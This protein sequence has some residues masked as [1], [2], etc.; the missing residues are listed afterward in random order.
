MYQSISHM[1]AAI[2]EKSF[3]AKVTDVT[4]ELGV[5]SIQGP[6]SREILSKVTDFNLSNQFIAPNSSAIIKIKGTEN[7]QFNV[8]MLRVSFVGELG[9]ELHIPKA[10]CAPV[11][12]ALMSAGSSYGLRNGGYR[13]LYALSSEKG[14]HLWGFDLRTDDTP[15]EANLGFTCRKNGEYKGKNAIEKQKKNGVHKRLVFLTL[16]DQNPLWG[17]EAVY[18]NG[19]LVGHLRR[20]DYGYSLNKSIGQFYIKRSDNKPVDDEYIKSGNYQIEIMGHK[21][22]A[23]CF[24]RSPFD[25]NGKRILGNYN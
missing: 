17:L 23:K 1:R 11:Y 21:Y 14:Y 19:D 16:N 13:S 5:L 18:R 12:N 6:K 24:I 9:F 25:S 15:L 3:R 10:A 8:R 4:E 20:G 7:T 2:Q 22:D